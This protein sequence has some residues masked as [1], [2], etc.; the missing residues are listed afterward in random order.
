M[1]SLYPPHRV[2]LTFLECHRSL[3]ACK[4]QI[5]NRLDNPKTPC[6]PQ[7]GLIITVRLANR[8]TRCKSW[9]HPHHTLAHHFAQR[10]S[11]SSP[12]TTID[13]DLCFGPA[14]WRLSGQSS[15]RIA[16]FSSPT[17]LASLPEGGRCEHRCPN[18]HHN[19][20]AS[21]GAQGLGRPAHIDIPYVVAVYQ[22]A[23]FEFRSVFARISTPLE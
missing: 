2:T 18:A 6:K 19:V 11:L 17:L 13:S 21:V 8:K 9:Q 1:L 22:A 14:L 20:Q 3:E 4:S 12:I 23:K 16:G 5:A 10:I 15:H 7:D